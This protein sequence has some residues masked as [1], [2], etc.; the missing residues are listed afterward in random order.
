MVPQSVL[1]A[2][3]GAQLVAEGFFAGALGAVV[4]SSATL[5]AGEGEDVATPTQQVT[6][7][8]VVRRRSGRPDKAA[9]LRTP[10][11]LADQG[12]AVQQLWQRHDAYE[13]NQTAALF[14]DRLQRGSDPGRL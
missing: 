6:V 11:Q 14:Q 8:G 7:P 3:V 13:E 2:E 10:L 9:Q 4:I 1:I 5:E 12:L